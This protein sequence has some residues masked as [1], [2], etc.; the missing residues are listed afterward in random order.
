MFDIYISGWSWFKKVD[1]FK[2]EKYYD[3]VSVQQIFPE[4]TCFVLRDNWETFFEELL[5][6]N[7]SAALGKQSRERFVWVNRGARFPWIHYRPARHRSRTSRKKTWELSEGRIE[8]RARIPHI[9]GSDSIHKSFLL[10]MSFVLHPAF[11]LIQ[12][13]VKGKQTKKKKEKAKKINKQKRWTGRDRL[14]TCCAET[15]NWGSPSPICRL[16]FHLRNEAQRGES[17]QKSLAETDN[18]AHINIHLTLGG[19]P[20]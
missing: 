9:S 7:R 4:G 13:E 11:L 12:K 6:V 5:R 3:V 16:N 19:M 15:D 2:V 17:L 8:G 1:S 20:L 10:K 18:T 14:D